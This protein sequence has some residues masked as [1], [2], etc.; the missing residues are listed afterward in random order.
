MQKK[1]RSVDPLIFY[2]GSNR[3]LGDEP[4][5]FMDLKNAKDSREKYIL[6]A[7]FLSQVIIVTSSTFVGGVAYSADNIYFS[8]WVNFYLSLYILNDW[9]QEKNE[10]C[11]RDLTHFSETLPGWYALLLSSTIVFGSVLNGV[12]IFLNDQTRSAVAIAIIASLI[13][14]IIS[15]TVILSFYKLCLCCSRERQL[16]VRGWWEFTLSL[17]LAVLWIGE[18]QCDR[19]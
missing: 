19:R 7:L 2:Y 16:P 14:M 5:N 18:S 12:E 13:S 17:G 15:S 4:A 9:M 8:V 6:I 11:F 3:R 1:K 10:I